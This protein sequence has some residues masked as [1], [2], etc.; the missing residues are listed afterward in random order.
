MKMHVE[1]IREIARVYAGA[2]QLETKIID[3]SGRCT[4]CAHNDDPVDEVCRCV[5]RQSCIDT[6]LFGARQA[7]AYGGSYVFFC[8]IGLVHFVSPVIRQGKMLSAVVS[9]H[10]LMTEPDVY[11]IRHILK[12]VKDEK[13]I[14]D[15]VQTI[16]V[17]DPAQVRDLAELLKHLVKGLSDD[18]DYLEA[19]LPK[20]DLSQAQ[21]QHSIHKVV[22]YIKSNY[23]ERLLLEEAAALVHISP[24][25]LSRI[26]KEE[27]GY[28]FSQ[29]VTR[30]RI[31]K[32][33]ALLIQEDLSQKDIALMTGFADQSHFSRS[34]K[35][36]TGLSP[37]TFQTR[38]G[39]YA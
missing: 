17:I 22:H 35:K 16:R 11:L 12:Y 34:F 36:V 6:H 26:F 38:E 15:F 2:T 28:T 30:I 27:T 25:Y 18:T 7:L 5:P 9:G 21:Y 3:G 10:I 32:S 39:L 4:Y 23:M 14:K 19:A 13:V 29:Y 24:Q 37:T 1:Q 31:E 33:K 20:G 8:P